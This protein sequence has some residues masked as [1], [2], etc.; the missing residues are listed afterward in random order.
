MG[1]TPKT[2]VEMIAEER[3]RQIAVKCFTDDHD[4]KHIAGELAQAAAYYADP[5]GKAEYPS[6]WHKRWDKK[7]KT[8][9]IRQLMIAGALCAAEIDR[10]TRQR[11]KKK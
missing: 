2:G 3:Q 5:A 7:D 10:I 1:M 9:R 11:I 8:D 6:D 4:D